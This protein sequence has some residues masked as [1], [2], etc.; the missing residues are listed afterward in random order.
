MLCVPDGTRTDATRLPFAKQC[1]LQ[2]PHPSSQWPGKD[3]T[4]AQDTAR[5]AMVPQGTQMCLCCALPG[6]ELVENA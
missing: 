6:V 4:P 5:F 3:R 1:V 2:S